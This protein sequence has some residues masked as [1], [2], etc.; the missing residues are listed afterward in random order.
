[1]SK[2]CPLKVTLSTVNTVIKENNGNIGVSTNESANLQGMNKVSIDTRNVMKFSTK[3]DCEYARKWIDSYSVLKQFLQSDELLLL[4]KVNLVDKALA[5][6]NC[7]FNVKFANFDEFVKFFSE[8]YCVDK[9]NVDKD[10]WKY[11][12]SMPLNKM[13]DHEQ[14]YVLKQ[15]AD[16][17]KMDFQ[18]IQERLKEV[19]RRHLLEKLEFC[20]SR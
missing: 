17:A 4:A 6:Y 13:D 14:I 3:E 10:S 5:W 2:K 8:K 16:L 7:Y 19:L 18:V 20:D 9:I 11:M 15:K 12:L 1:M